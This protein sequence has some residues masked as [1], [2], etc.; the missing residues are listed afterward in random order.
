MLVILSVCIL[1]WKINYAIL[2][3][4]LEESALYSTNMFSLFVIQWDG[5]RH[6][7]KKV[8]KKMLL[9]K[10]QTQSSQKQGEEDLRPKLIF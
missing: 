7:R 5:Q 9:L 8:H 10:L 2:T 3:D 6:Q 4:Y 1:M